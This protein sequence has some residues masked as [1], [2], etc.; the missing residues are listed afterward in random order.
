MLVVP[1]QPLPNQVLQ[2]VLGGQACTIHIYQKRT[3]LYLDLAVNDAP[4]VA[5][6]LCLVGVRL[7]RS[8]YL[9][10]A[11]DLAFFDTR[12]GDAPPIAGTP[13]DEVSSA[14]LGE[15]YFLAYLP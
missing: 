15:R 10:F 11:G 4:V 9:G 12:P 8:G 6:V 13:P 5:G 3:G 1:T 14:G 2:V 7:V